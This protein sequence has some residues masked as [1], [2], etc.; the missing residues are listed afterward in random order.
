MGRMDQVKE[1]IEKENVVALSGELDRLD[2]KPET[3][4]QHV[5]DLMREN[6]ELATRRLNELLRSPRFSR[7]K[8][9]DQAKLIA[10]AQERAYGK[11][12]A[13]KQENSRKRGGMKD[14]I[15]SELDNM[16][17]RTTLPEYRKVGTETPN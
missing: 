13:P 9:G 3:I 5:W 16:A 15:N 11:T 17:Y 7:L 14:V 1:E 4:P 8:A 10:L 12:A 6:G 2:G